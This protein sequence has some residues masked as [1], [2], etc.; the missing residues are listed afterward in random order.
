MHGIMS[1]AL[2]TA[3][4]IVCNCASS[5]SICVVYLRPAIHT[6]ILYRPPATI[7]LVF[8]RA[9]GDPARARIPYP[10]HTAT[11]TGLKALILT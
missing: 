11:A 2:A 3:L 10:A 8:T 4:M 5:T 7:Q 1:V 9:L 6:P